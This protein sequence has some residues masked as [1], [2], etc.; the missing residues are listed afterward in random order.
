MESLL[1]F[2]ITKI[3]KKRLRGYK[4]NEKNLNLSS[5]I[6]FYVWILFDISSFSDP[7]S[8]VNLDYFCLNKT[9]LF[10]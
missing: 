6:K 2:N 10:F 8:I 9:F 1:E 4:L 3:S 5:L 7:T